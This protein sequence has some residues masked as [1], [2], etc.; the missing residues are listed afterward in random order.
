MLTR[1]Y[2]EA[3][4]ADPEAADQVW[5]LWDSRL[6]DDGLAATAWCILTLSNR[7]RGKP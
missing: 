6:I 7:D 5:E 4:L 2:V 1:Q 3:I